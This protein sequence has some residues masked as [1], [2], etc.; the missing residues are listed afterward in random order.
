MLF[1]SLNIGNSTTGRLYFSQATLGS[2][3]TTVIPS[4]AFIGTTNSPITLS[5]LADNSLSFDGSSGQLFSINNNLSSGWIFAVN[6]ISGL[7]L[8]RA[9]ADGT[10]AMGEFAG[11]IGLG[12]SNPSYKL[13]VVGDTNLSSSYVYRINGTSVLSASS[14]G[15]GVTNSSLTAVGT[16][17][18]G[19]WAGSTI[20]AKY[21]G[22]GYTTYTKGDLLV[23]AGGTFIKFGSG[24]NNQDR[25]STRL[26]SSHI[27]LSRMP[28][29]A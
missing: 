22:T 12:I 18:T 26:N 4:M 10:V 20:T 23:G 16:I 25:K 3:G 28:S 5:V 19:T 1:R 6:D 24:S 9:N 11:N 15:T 14:L 13:H 8:I 21:G 27:P 7:P 29:S 17:S 2:A